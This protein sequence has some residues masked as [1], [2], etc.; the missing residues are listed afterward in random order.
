MKYITP[1]FLI[2]ILGSWLP[3]YWGPVIMMR[4]YAPEN[5][6]YIFG[7]RIMLV[8]IFVTLAVA[9]KIAWSKKR[10]IKRE[11]AII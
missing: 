2:V 3:Q 8:V 10:V 4:G 5:Y 1:T 7:I 6:P 11:V 9:V